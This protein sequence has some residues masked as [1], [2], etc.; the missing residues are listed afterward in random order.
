MLHPSAAV[1]PAALATAE[2]TG[3]G[4]RS[5]LAAAAMGIEVTCRLGMAGYDEDLGNSV[6]FEP[7]QHA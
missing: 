4:G 1:V 6:F 5:L 2:R 7:L 3:A